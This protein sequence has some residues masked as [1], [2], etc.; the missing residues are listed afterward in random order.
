MDSWIYYF[1]TLFYFSRLFKIL[2]L[3][4]DFNINYLNNEAQKIL[5]QDLLLSIGMRTTS[6]DPTR[7][8]LNKHGKKSSSKLD[9]IITND[10]Y[11][12]NKSLMIQP[13]FADHLALIYDINLE[14]PVLNIN[15]L[16]LEI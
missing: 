14:K 16:D 12:D 6:L 10:N 5:L 1:D 15:S 7:I 13:N 11:I 2:Y 8:F 9:Y 4:G 3:T